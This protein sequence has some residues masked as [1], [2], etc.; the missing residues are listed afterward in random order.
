M[1]LHITANML[2][3]ALRAKL[4]SGAARRAISELI[5]RYARDGVTQRRQD[6]V[7]RLPVEVIPYERRASFLDALNELPENR[8][9]GMLFV[10]L[11]SA[12]IAGAPDI[13]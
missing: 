11:R 9:S 1:D 6:G 3:T 2:R 8:S 12:A 4:G 7:Y 5:G 10:A 13:V